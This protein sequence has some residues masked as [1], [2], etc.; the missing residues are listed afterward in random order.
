MPQVMY[1]Y[2]LDKTGLNPANSV[3]GE[4]HTLEPAQQYRVLIP[5]YAPFFTQALTVRDNLTNNLLTRGV[6]YKVVELAQEPSMLY[7]KEIC[8][9]ILISNQNVSN[10]IRIDY[11]VLGGYYT[12]Q[13]ANLETMYQAFINDQRPIEFENVINK[14]YQYNPT[15]HTNYLEDLYG[16]ENVVYALEKIERA[17]TVSNLPIFDSLIEYINNRIVSS[18]TAGALIDDKVVIAKNEIDDKV[19][20]ILLILNNAQLNY[21]N[22]TTTH[23]QLLRD[24]IDQF[25]LTLNNR[26]DQELVQRDLYLQNALDLLN[27]MLGIKNDF[28]DWLNVKLRERLPFATD[29]QIED[30]TAHGLALTYE[31]VI[32]LIE[33]SGANQQTASISVASTAIEEGNS[34]SV[35]VNTVNVADNTVYVWE[36]VNQTTDD[37]DFTVKTGNITILNNTAS[38]NISILEDNLIEPEQTFTVRVRRYSSTGRIMATSPALTIRD[39][40]F[41]RVSFV[42]PPTSVNEGDSITFNLSASN[43]PNNTTYTWNVTGDTSVSEFTSGNVTFN[44]DAASFTL[45]LKFNYVTDPDK[46]FAIEIRRADNKVLTSTPLI[47]L[48]DVYFEEPI[49]DDVYFNSGCFID[50]SSPEGMYLSADILGIKGTLLQ[51]DNFH[52]TNTDKNPYSV[53]LQTPVSVPEASTV[54]VP[55][56]TISAPDGTV[57]NWQAVGEGLVTTS[58]SFTINSNAAS[59]S[60]TTITNYTTDADKQFSIIVRDNLGRI[61][62]QSA[63]VTVTDVYTPVPVDTALEDAYLNCCL[64]PDITDAEAFYFTQQRL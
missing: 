36:V 54:L 15:A 48:T 38:F 39:L 12:N 56:T 9:V 41:Y 23:I 52:V 58:G 5:T 8:S 29:Q 20:Q 22:H 33:D 35:I 62:Y 30:E 25:L 46:Q 2:E 7:G 32:Q 31:Q 26:K 47:T 17:L 55:V 19:N 6:D 27:Q 14:P 45:P 1:R 57:Y 10:E 64:N 3:V 11:Q 18:Q 34:L 37:N 59:I 43:I 16:F 13:S 50:M 24:I 61:V 53:A 21:T 4:I 44:T 40:N 60:L 51:L 49:V 63:N 28:A 42:S